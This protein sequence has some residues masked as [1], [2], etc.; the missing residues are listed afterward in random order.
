MA[1]PFN[2]AGAYSDASPARAL[3]G[4][5]SGAALEATRGAFKT[6]PLRGVARTA[7]YMHTGAFPTLRDV[8]LFYRD[9]GGAGGFEGTKDIS[10]QPLMLS[11]QDVDDLVAFLESLSGAPLPQALASAPRL[12]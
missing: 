5:P 7:P 8:V 3:Q 2:A 12:P 6:S 10:M 11:D 1:D 4:L 9:G